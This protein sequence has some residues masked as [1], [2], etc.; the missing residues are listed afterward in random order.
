MGGLCWH[1]GVLYGPPCSLLAILLGRW[2]GP[3]QTGRLQSG[4]QLS[5]GVHGAGE[6]ATADTEAADQQGK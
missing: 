3:E 1:G 5:K 4:A 6:Q 2:L